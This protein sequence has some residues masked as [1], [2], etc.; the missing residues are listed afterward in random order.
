[1]KRKIAGVPISLLLLLSV[2]AARLTPHRSRHLQ[3]GPL[4]EPV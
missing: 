4:L 1:M 2:R 3:V